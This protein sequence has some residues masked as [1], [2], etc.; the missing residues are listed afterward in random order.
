MKQP[1]L[2]QKNTELIGSN[3]LFLQQLFSQMLTELKLQNFDINIFSKQKNREIIVIVRRISAQHAHRLQSAV[4]IQNRSQ[5]DFAQLAKITEE[6]FECIQ[7]YVQDNFPS[8]REIAIQLDNVHFGSKRR[9][10][11]KT[12]FHDLGQAVDQKEIHITFSLTQGRHTHI[13]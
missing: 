1:D 7:R 5:F 13:G 10:G 12:S 4:R 3:L 11:K 2:F 8:R 6:E 9:V